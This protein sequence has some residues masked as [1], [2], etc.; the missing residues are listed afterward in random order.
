[1]SLSGEQKIGIFLRNAANI[2]MK[3]NMLADFAQ[4]K[5]GA[6]REGIP[7][8]R[9]LIGPKKNGSCEN[10]LRK[11]SAGNMCIIYICVFVWPK[12]RALA[13]ERAFELKFIKTPVNCCFYSILSQLPRAEGKYLSKRREV[14]CTEG[15]VLVVHK[16]QCRKLDS[17]KIGPEGQREGARRNRGRKN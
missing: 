8:A 5:Y 3:P 17:C 4:A 12:K 14:L 10:Q 7:A 9:F 11:M 2:L 13:A 1:M 6:K 16:T 15:Q